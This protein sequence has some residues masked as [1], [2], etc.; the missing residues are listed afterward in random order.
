MA[1][2]QTN[3]FWVSYAP[4]EQESF[5]DFLNLL[6]KVASGDSRK[7]LKKHG[8]FAGEVVRGGRRC[9]DAVLC[10]SVR[11]PVSAIVS[12]T[13]WKR[14]GAKGSLVDAKW[15]ASGEGPQ[16]F[17]EKWANAMRAASLERFS[18]SEIE[19][20]RRLEEYRHRERNRVR[21]ARDK[22]GRRR[23]DRCR[24]RSPLLP[25]VP[26]TSP[27]SEVSATVVDPV[28][29]P[30][31]GPVNEFTGIDFTLPVEGLCTFFLYSVVTQVKRGFYP[32]GSKLTLFCWQTRLWR[33]RYLLTRGWR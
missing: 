21:K 28:V 27:E 19:L 8:V 3:V 2:T 6:D 20:H 12:S 10:S 32:S 33:V 15:P 25:C 23:P 30:S 11:V 16:V 5:R 13:K 4:A 22:K 18:G 14:K 1:T 7:S 31:D 26:P 9:V 29:V 17:M 24:E